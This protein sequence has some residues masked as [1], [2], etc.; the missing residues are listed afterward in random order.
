M[1]AMRTMWRI[2]INW[3][4]QLW[5]INRRGTRFYIRLYPNP[6]FMVPWFGGQNLKWSKFYGWK[7]SPGPGN[8]T[9][10]SV[11][12]IEPVSPLSVAARL[13]KQRVGDQHAIPTKLE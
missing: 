6:G 1:G 12:S 8:A 3:F 10:E 9:V 13:K 4:N 11:Q 2:L 7:F 5:I